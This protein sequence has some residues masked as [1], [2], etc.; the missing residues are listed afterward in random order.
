MQSRDVTVALGEAVLAFECGDYA[1]AVDTLLPVKY[2]IIRIG[3]SDAQVC[4]ATVAV[5][6][7]FPVSCVRLNDRQ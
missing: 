6:C 3:G 5:L 2:D 7:L 1:T 4:S